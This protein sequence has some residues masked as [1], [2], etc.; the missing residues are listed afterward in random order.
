[1]K[2]N[3]PLKSVK[4]FVLWAIFYISGLVTALE[5]LN[6]ITEDMFIGSCMLI[7]GGTGLLFARDNGCK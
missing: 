1:M 3:S 6:V 5:S 4:A 7:A 2:D